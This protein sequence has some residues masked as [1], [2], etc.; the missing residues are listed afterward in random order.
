MEY[1][2]SSVGKVLQ[3]EMIGM[4]NSMIK[5]PMEYCKPRTEMIN[6]KESVLDITQ[7]DQIRQPTLLWL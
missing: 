1:P 5:W 4:M 3:R 7:Q 2:V 6:A